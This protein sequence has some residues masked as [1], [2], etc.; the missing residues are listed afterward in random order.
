MCEIAKPCVAARDAFTR[1][2][3][4]SDERGEGKRRRSVKSDNLTCCRKG[5]CFSAVFRARLPIY[6]RVEKTGLR[7]LSYGFQANFPIGRTP[8]VM[9][10]LPLHVRCLLFFCGLKAVRSSFSAVFSP[11]RKSLCRRVQMLRGK[12]AALFAA[13]EVFR[14][15]CVRRGCNLT[16]AKHFAAGQ[17]VAIFLKKGY[18][19]TI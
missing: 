4:N 1:M 18:N 14:R 2:T 15:G 16:S 12:T 8:M 3:V 7:Q 9:L 5:R 6:F 17:T 11:F 19:F 10:F 13:V